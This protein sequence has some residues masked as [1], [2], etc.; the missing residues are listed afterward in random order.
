M[1]LF[2]CSN[3][4]D[5]SNKETPIYYAFNVSSVSN[6]PMNATEEEKKVEI[7]IDGITHTDIAPFDWYYRKNTT[8]NETNIKVSVNSNKNTNIIYEVRKNEKFDERGNELYPGDLI[9]MNN[10]KDKLDT[11]IKLK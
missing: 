4:D 2:S 8:L 3:D 11:I 9:F 10:F 6:Y 1:L 5:D 7:T